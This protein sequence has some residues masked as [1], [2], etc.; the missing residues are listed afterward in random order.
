LIA[1]AIVA[2]GR[3]TR[4]GGVPK[5]TLLIGGRR[6]VDRQLEVLRAVFPRVF[7]VA[8]D[9]APW[10]GLGVAVVPDR[11]P[12][13]GPLAGIDAALAALTDQESAVACVAG[14]MPFLSVA[15]LELLRDHAPAAP[16]VAAPGQPLFARY[17]RAC[18]PA[19]QRALA[20]GRLQARALLDELSAT[21]LEDRALR[22]L[23]PQLTF[24]GNVNTPADLDATARGA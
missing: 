14:D 23:D 24:L 16:L 17:G 19:V 2:G 21:Y 7:L 1:A 10:T 3:A 5:G 22:A 13:A 12:G 15:A 9:P 11:L 4:L 8:N 20:E 18:A 6:I